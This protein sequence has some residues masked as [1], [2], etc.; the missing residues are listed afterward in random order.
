[1]RKF[2]KNIA[3]TFGYDILHL[4]VNPVARRHLDLLNQYGVDMIF[5]VGA[6]T[7]QFAR[8][9][10]EWGYQGRI[11]SFE[12]LPDAFRELERSAAGDDR[13][14]AVNY[15]LGATESEELLN[16]SENSYSSSILSMTDAHL[17]S[18]PG[19]GYT[20]RKEAI[21]VKTLDSVID[22]YYEKGNSLFVKIDTQGYERQVLSGSM[23]SMER[24]AGFQMELS[25]VPLYEGETLMAEM[26][27]LLKG[28]G[29]TLKLM[30]AG[31]ADYTTGEILQVEGY[32]Y[33]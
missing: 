22:Q 21:I 12:P 9:M 24:I 28:Y 2:L 26:I 30:E 25:L 10:R 4:P 23:G 19:S 7:G 20:G 31:H 13:W 16:I 8:R 14:S 33:R 15:A 6:N 11:V 18:A 5:D 32:F 17:Q 29:Y 3:N 27:K 1:M